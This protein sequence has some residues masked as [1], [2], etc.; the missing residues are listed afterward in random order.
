MSH[1]EA[2]VAVVTG[3]S[4]GIGYATSEL[5]R[6]QGLAVIGLARGLKDSQWT[7]SCDVRD[8]EKVEAV[9]H[10]IEIEFG[11][12]DLL[13][14]CAGITSLVSD[15]LSYSAKDWEEIFQT[16]LIGMY[17]CCKHALSKM[18]RHG[19]GRIVN[20][21][22]I[23]AR[24]YSRTASLPYTCSKYGVIGLTRQLAENFGSQGIT[25]N[26]VCPSQ[27]KTDMLIKNV[28]AD[29]LKE[30]AACVP[31]GRLAE[32][33]EIAQVIG[34]LVSDSALYVNGA[35]IDINGGQI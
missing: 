9:F 8:E 35:V 11:H 29:I 5:L 16:N 34:F 13:V 25:I 24:S 28:K 32:P 7:R 30:R 14:N 33:E 15:P 2:R 21:S 17:H 4:S 20:V 6:S 27:T 3:A 10:E 31:L 26:C 12:L 23:A 18:V 1:S 19:Y 22:S